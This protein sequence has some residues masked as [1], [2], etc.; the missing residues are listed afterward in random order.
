MYMIARD[1]I[2]V[3]RRDIARNSLYASS[4]LINRLSYSTVKFLTYIF[5]AVGFQFTRSQRKIAEE[6]LRIAFGREKNKKEIDR[7][8]KDCFVNVGKGM[9]E[10]IY[11]M[12][13]PKMIKEKVLFEG[14]EHLDEAFRYGKGVIAVSAH[15]GNFPLMLLRFAQEGYK[16][17][18]IIRPASDQQIEEYFV[19]LRTRLGLYTIYSQ[20]RKQ[21]VDASLRALRNNEFLFIPLDQNFGSSGGVFVDFFGQKAATATGPV[22][23]AMR[24]KAP[25]LPVFTV[26]QPDDTHKIII[27]EPLLLEEK[28]TDEETILANTAR[29]TA[30]IERYIRWFPHEWGWMHRRWKT[31]PPEGEKI[32]TGSD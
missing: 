18:A 26:R 27:E 22:V 12:S 14:K 20:P 19:K 5:I 23:F 7:I 28:G 31:R 3:L 11:F 10:L 9:I 17:S 4:W 6:S 29:I 30:I 2:K 32:P 16:T 24:T 15:F 13:H 25:I 8:I 21:C 1:R